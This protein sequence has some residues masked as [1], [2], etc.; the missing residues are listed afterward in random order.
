MQD[1]ENNMDDLFRSAAA[2]YPLKTGGDGWHL[3]AVRLEDDTNA[4]A[5]GRKK[6]PGEKHIVILLFLFLLVVIAGTAT[7]DIYTAVATAAGEAEHINKKIPKTAVVKIRNYPGMVK[8]FSGDAGIQQG[9]VGKMIIVP[10]YQLFN[11]AGNNAGKNSTGYYKNQKQLKQIADPA[12]EHAPMGATVYIA[13]T[14]NPRIDLFDSASVSSDNVTAVAG[15]TENNRNI[16][17]LANIPPAAKAGQ[18]K[19]ASFYG[20]LVFGPS[21]NQVKNQGLRKPGFDIGLL[22]GFQFT[23]RL[24]FETGVLFEK[25]YYFSNGKYFNMSKTSSAMPAGMKVLNLEGSCSIIEI[26]FKVKYNFFRRREINFYSSAGI[27]G[28]IVTGEYNKYHAIINGTQL[29][30]AGS[31]KTSSGYTAA[32]LL[33]SAGYENRIGKS[34]SFIRIEPYVQIPLR[35]IGVGSLPVMTAGLHI[36]FAGFI[37]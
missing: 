29:D 19:K 36:G 3:I 5:A 4:V 33:L 26:P 34:S 13:D 32:V 6:R 37:K 10:P 18:N 21:F 9:A 7:R 24:S 12:V 31:Y 27:S 14:V 22:A 25:K 1:L 20:G 8:T 2:G 35:G 30:I 28:Y 17:S 15:V 16:D 23:N 11:A